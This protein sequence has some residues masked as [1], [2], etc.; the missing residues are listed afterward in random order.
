[1]VPTRIE[2]ME[3]GNLKY[4]S[5][6]SDL[7]DSEQHLKTAEDT[8]DV[9]CHWSISPAWCYA[10]TTLNRLEKKRLRCL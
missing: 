8:V 1:M 3:Q 9:N 6:C 4:P 5:E 7:H 10:I 2:Q